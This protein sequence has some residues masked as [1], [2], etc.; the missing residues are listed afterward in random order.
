MPDARC[1]IDSFNFEVCWIR[2]IGVISQATGVCIECVLSFYEGRLPSGL[3]RAPN[4]GLH[5]VE[6]M[7]FSVKP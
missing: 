6:V 1:L 3:S 2:Y 4:V 5:Q 7:L